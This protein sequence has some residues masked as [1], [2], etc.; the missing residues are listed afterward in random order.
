MERQIK[1]EVIE[2]NKTNNSKNKKHLVEARGVFCYN[3]EMKRVGVL[4]G[5]ASE[6]YKNSLFLGG[7]VIAHIHEN[8]G[9]KY[10]T[11]DILIDKDGV[12]HLNGLPINPSDLIH[13]VDIVWNL[14][15]SQFSKIVENLS[16]PCVGGGYFFNAL[17]NSSELLRSHMKKIGVPMPKS[18]VLPLYQEDFDGLREKYAIKKAKEIHEKFGA[19]W[20]VKSF[21]PDKD[22]GM[23]VAKTFGELVGAIEDGVNHGKSILV[24]EL[25]MGKVA[26]IHSVPNF[27]NEKIYTFPFGKYSSSFSIEEKEKLINFVKNLHEHIDAKQYL[28][29][30]FVLSP[31]RGVC[32]LSIESIPDLRYDS[33]FSEACEGAGLKMHHIIEYILEGAL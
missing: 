12:W 18:V 19:P 15:E 27:R 20:I 24:E 10:K 5:G 31:T 16:I 7:T 23:H 22:M 13:K 28:K 29:S 11:V 30:N 26:S 9:E 14:S 3:V 32:L 8:L 1:K 6:N 17:E 33:H 2:R 4:R 21:T 25:I